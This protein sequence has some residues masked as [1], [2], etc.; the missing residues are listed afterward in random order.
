MNL[1]QRYTNNGSNF[2]CFLVSDF[3][4]SDCV[5]LKLEESQAKLSSIFNSLNQSNTLTNSTLTASNQSASQAPFN[6]RFLIF[7]WPVVYHC[8][9]NQMVS[10]FRLS[11]TCCV[12]HRH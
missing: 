3:D 7:G 10:V 11:L 4:Q 5:F 8:L 12:R 6:K 1:T 2:V 9:Q